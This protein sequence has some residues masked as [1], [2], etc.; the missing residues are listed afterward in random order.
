MVWLAM[1]RIAATTSASNFVA[2]SLTN[3]SRFQRWPN[4]PAVIDPPETLEM[5]ASFGRYPASFSRQ[6]EPTWKSIAR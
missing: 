6:S 1:A 4:T 5:R 3:A 2:T